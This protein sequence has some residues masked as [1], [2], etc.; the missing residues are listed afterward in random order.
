MSA[1]AFALV[2]VAACIH[3]AWNFMLKRAQADPVAMSWLAASVGAV[4]YAPLALALHGGE[5][6]GLSA[7][8]LWAVLVSGVVHV[9][10]FIVLQRGYQV[11]DLSVVYPVARGVGPLMSSVVAIAVLGEAASA[12]SVA[13]LALVVAGTFTIAGGVS[14]LRGWSPR[15]GAGLG[16]GA[17]TGVLIAGY[18]VND[19]NAVRALGVSPLLFYWLSDTSRAL[20]LAPWAAR[21]A[22]QV[23]E[24]L[25]HAWRPMLAV[26]LLSPAGYILVLIAMTMAPISHVAPAREVSMLIAAFLGAKLLAEGELRRRLAGAALIASG[27]A[28]L[29]LA[30]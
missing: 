11:A 25:A 24:S 30:K 5:L 12:L 21:R 29:A 1:G 4:A 7:A 17:L 20:L 15:T 13:G 28:C 6:P 27:V 10:Y 22:P 19:G 14:M 3:A 8:A 2:L 23:R 18:T 26:A 16:W 9:A